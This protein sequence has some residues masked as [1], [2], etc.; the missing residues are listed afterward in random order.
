MRSRKKHGLSFYGMG[1][2]SKRRNRSG[3]GFW[4]FL[5]AHIGEIMMFL[6]FFIMDLSLRIMGHKIEFYPAYYLQPNLF[7]I[8]WAGLFIAFAKYL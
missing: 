3:M 6:P 2:S 7:T 4:S 8:I 5:A 1:D